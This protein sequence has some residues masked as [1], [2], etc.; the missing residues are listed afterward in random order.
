MCRFYMHAPSQDAFFG[1]LVQLPS[2]T[3]GS[4]FKAEWSPSA[5][6]WMFQSVR[7]GMYLSIDASGVPVQSASADDVRAQFSVVSVD[8]SSRCDFRGGLNSGDV[9]C[10]SSCGTCGG[11]GCSGRNGGAAGCCTQDIAQNAGNA[12]CGNP[13]CR[14]GS[15]PVVTLQSRATFRYLHVAQTGQSD[16]FAT[17]DSATTDST[18]FEVVSDTASQCPPGFVGP[19]GSPLVEDKSSAN[20]AACS[21]GTFKTASGSSACLACPAHSTTSLLPPV[22]SA[23]RRLPPW[24]FRPLHG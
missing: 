8:M 18:A 9:C 12:T 20:C 1:Q 3:D 21:E 16:P 2:T 10:A 19:D 5:V 23:G 15:N 17:L 7:T 11:T 13:P 4:K 6:S 24:T 14:L 22:A